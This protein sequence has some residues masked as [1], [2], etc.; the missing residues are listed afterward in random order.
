M[1]SPMV[2]KDMSWLA[3]EI[4]MVLRDMC[5]LA[6]EIT[7]VLKDMSWLAYEITLVLKEGMEEQTQCRVSLKFFFLKYA[8]LTPLV[9]ANH[10]TKNTLG[11]RSLQSVNI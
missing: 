6:Y 8:C 5:W 11:K 7:M 9:C 4:T 2:L 3:Y 10:H 1:K